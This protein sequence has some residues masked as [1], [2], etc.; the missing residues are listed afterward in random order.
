M[1]V[2]CLVLAIGLCSCGHRAPSE[3]PSP[4]KLTT[5]KE[6]AWTVHVEYQDDGP[7]D[8]SYRFDG[9]HSALVFDSSNYRSTSW[10]SEVPGTRIE[11]LHGLDVLLLEPESSQAQFSVMPTSS[12]G[13]GPAP[14][15]QFSDK[16]VA[17]HVAQFSLLTVSSREEAEALHGNLGKWHGTQPT[18]ALTLTSKQMMLTPDG[19]WVSGVLQMPVRGGGGYIYLGNIK[20]VETDDVVAVVDPGLPDWLANRFHMDISRIYDAHRTRWGARTN[21][22]MVLLAFGGT[23]GGL[24]NRGFAAG[25]QLSMLIRGSAYASENEDALRTL[26]WFFAHE[27]SHQF[28]FRGGFSREAG[29]DWISEGSANTM[30]IAVLHDL[31]MMD[32]ARMERRY[33]RTHRRCV[34]ELQ[35]GPLEGK[36]GEAGYVCGDLIAQM[37]AASLPDHDLFAFWNAF[38]KQANGD[39]KRLTSEGYFAV[40][41]ER[42]ADPAFVD[43]LVRLIRTPLDSAEAQLA[44]AMRAS[45]L[46]P[47][48]AADGGLV[49]M[50]FP[51]A[52][53]SAD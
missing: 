29:A 39:T 16:S 27:A 42:G 34:T 37:T 20:P 28:Q 30:A 51:A 18:L 48:F 44:E 40:L 3:K 23:E 4:K 8:I 13:R 25:S 19:R 53:P 1:N 46:V 31:G 45:G 14:F 24:E 7:W 38:R 2:P 10:S 21:R 52:M 49:T 50:K 6:Q 47:Q 11:N 36:R 5:P 41:R 26:L 32:K 33:W 9:A 43:S 35:D 17:V 22:A 12:T 15:L